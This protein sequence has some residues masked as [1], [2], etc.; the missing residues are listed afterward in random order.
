MKEF[1][2]YLG[3]IITLIGVCVFIAYALTST[4]TNAYLITGLSLVIV[5]ILAQIVLNKY[6]QD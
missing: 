1:L 4:P 6:I 5:G 2:K 3:V